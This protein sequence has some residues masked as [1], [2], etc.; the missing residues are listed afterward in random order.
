MNYD[1][2]KLSNP[3]D[4][5]CG[6]NIISDCCGAMVYDDT[7]I[8]SDCKEHCEPMEDYEYEALKREAWEEMMADGRRDEG[9]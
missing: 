3:I 1:Q 6:Y 7:D 8:C 9:L 2:W 5:G 4:D